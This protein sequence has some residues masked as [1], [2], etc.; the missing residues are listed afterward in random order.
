MIIWLGLVTFI[1][2]GFP[3]FGNAVVSSFQQLAQQAG[4]VPSSP[5][6]VMNM[7]TNIGTSI[8]KMGSILHPATAAGIIIAASFAAC[9]FYVV[10][11]LMLLS[12][13][14]AYVVIAIAT[15]FLGFAG[16]DFTMPI[17]RGVLHAVVSAGARLF[18][19]QLLAGIGA[20]LI[21]GWMGQTTALDDAS[22]LT[23]IGLA[24][25]YVIIVF[26]VPAA[27]ESMANGHG[28]H[29]R[30]G[31]GEMMRVIAQN[32]AMLA[33]V[34]RGVNNLASAGASMMSALPGRGGGGSSATPPPMIGG[35]S[36]TS[37]ATASAAGQRMRP[38]N[39]SFSPRSP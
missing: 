14:K 16:H 37:T 19:I 4:S 8:M 10:A 13:A 21:R 29:A 36:G 2:Q 7:G 31:P 12:L 34:S 26:S 32:T 28:G 23:T 9:A 22:M 5:T 6:D 33:S 30:V 24:I 20:T 18:T 35:S 27:V 1:I 38:Q 3:G 25:V 11:A 39:A 17:A 15:L